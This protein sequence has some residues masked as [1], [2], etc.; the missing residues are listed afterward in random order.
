[1]AATSERRDVLLDGFAD[2]LAGTLIEKTLGL[3]D[4]HAQRTTAQCIGDL[5]VSHLASLSYG[6]SQISVARN[7]SVKGRR[8]NPEML[9]QLRIG[10][11]QQPELER[12]EGE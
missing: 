2:N 7:P 11:P 8:R 1:M 5:R 3:R 9:R 10:Q 4:R 6:H 12:P